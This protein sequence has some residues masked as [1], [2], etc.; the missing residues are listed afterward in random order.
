MTRERFFQWAKM[1]ARA[2]ARE[3]NAIIISR[4]NDPEEYP[5]TDELT[6]A[7]LDELIRQ[8]AERIRCIEMDTTRTEVHEPRT[9]T[10][11]A[12]LEEIE[13]RRDSVLAECN[14]NLPTYEAK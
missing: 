7:E 6:F 12:R 5:V 3:Q 10:R 2:L 14:P 11:E 9:P 8:T 1:Y 13:R 4:V